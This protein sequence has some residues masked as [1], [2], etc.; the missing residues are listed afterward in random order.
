MY[1]QIL[2]GISL[3]LLA[4][5]TAWLLVRPEV[6]ESVGDV[7]APPVISPTPIAFVSQES[8]ESIFVTFGTSTALLNGIGYSNVLLQQVEAASG[9]KYESEE[10]NL[11]VWNKD[12]EVT[13]TRG[14][15]VL[16]TGVS[17]DSQPVPVEETS[18]TSATTTVAASVEGSW[19]W[20]ETSKGDQTIIPKEAGAFSVTFSA[21]SLSGT[22][23]CND[24]SGTY[25]VTSNTITIGAVAMSKKFCEDSQE[26][27]FTQQFIGSLTVSQVGDALTL[28]HSDGTISR[29]IAK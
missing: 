7:V 18:S 6:H 5:A 20:V 17:Q 25:T 15:K 19:L 3:L 13:V 22:T 2:I 1:K 28:T 11:T 27:E 10:E 24:F 21:G 14:R 23:D 29:Y 26:M 8:G 12:T 16:F 9:A 4:I